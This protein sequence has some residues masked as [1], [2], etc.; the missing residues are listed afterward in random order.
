[1]AVEC[2]QTAH[3][4]PTDAR[5]FRGLEAILDKPVLLGIVVSNE[6]GP[7]SLSV[8]GCAFPVWAVPAPLLFA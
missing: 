1:V 2:K 6:I 3:V 8:P 4:D 7:R 5:H